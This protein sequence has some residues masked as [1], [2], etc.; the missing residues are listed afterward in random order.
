MILLIDL[1]VNETKLHL[2]LKVFMEIK[3]SVQV[4][5]NKMTNRKGILARMF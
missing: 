1:V 2:F 3:I 4:E 5:L